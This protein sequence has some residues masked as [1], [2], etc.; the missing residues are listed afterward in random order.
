M[1]YIS[2]QYSFKII[3]FLSRNLVEFHK[4]IILLPH[5]FKQESKRGL[6]DWT[7]CPCM[8]IYKLKNNNNT[9]KN[10]SQNI[11]IFA[12][13]FN[14]RQTHKLP[15]NYTENETVVNDYTFLLKQVI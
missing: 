15:F 7:L 5:A 4:G 14:H 2:L 9:H 11:E 6:C 13:K 8:Y 3:T 10:K 1:Q 12:M